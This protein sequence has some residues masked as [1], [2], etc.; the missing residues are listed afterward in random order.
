MWNKA[1]NQAGVKASSALRRAN[2]VYYPPAICASGPPNSF[3]P[4]ADTV[5]KEADD[6]KD[7][8]AKVLP[9]SNSP[10]KGA[11]QAKA[12]EKGKDTTKG[13]V[14]EATKPP[15]VPKDPSKG[16]EAS[17]SVEIVLATLPIPT[18]EDSKGKGPTSIAV[19]TAKS[20]KAIG[21]ENLPFKIN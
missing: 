11:E 19:E 16:K 17:Q 14:P 20:T 10:P 1:L 6:D 5:S 18:K 3:G 12:P 8:T 7:S 4:K 13:V 2:N 9:S 15:I 21:K